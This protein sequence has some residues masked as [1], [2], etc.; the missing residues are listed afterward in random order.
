MKVL[1]IDTASDI[2]AVALMTD[3]GWAEASLNL[4]LKHAERLM[5]T[6]DFCLSRAELK[7]EE[8]DLIACTAGP[9]SFTG[10]RIGMAT[11][12]GLS[13]AL[14][15][16]WVSVPTLDCLA[17]GLEPYQGVVAPV[18][19]GKKGRFYTAFYLKGRRLS[20]YLDISL[21]RFASLVDT[22]PETLVTGPDAALFEE[23]ALERSGIQIDRRAGIPAARALAVLAA[24]KFAKGGPSA[25][26]EGPLYLRPSEAEEAAAGG[27]GADGAS[28]PAEGKTVL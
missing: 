27:G 28:P 15:K 7:P 8:L 13:L 10:L 20:D 23:L 21:A 6:V 4:G 26:D 24:E 14:R 12:K 3:A 19:D 9:G 18:M 2:L 5:D 11:V 25:N 16:P 1:A 22:Y 17:W